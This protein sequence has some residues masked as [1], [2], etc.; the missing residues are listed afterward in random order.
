MGVR[1]AARFAVALSV[2]V[3]VSLLG[4]AGPT[5]P[6]E[7]RAATLPARLHGVGRLHRP[8]EPDRRA[9]RARRP[10][11]RGREER[12]DQG[13][14]Q[15]RRHDADG[16]RR[17]PHRG[18]QLLG[19]RPARPGARPELPGR[20]RTSTCS[21]RYDAPIGGT[22]PRWGIAGGDARTAARRRPAPTADGC[23]VSGR[24]SR[25]QA[26]GNVMT[27]AEQVLIEDWCQQFPSHSIGD[28][29]FGP[30]GA[31]YV[32]GGDGA[33]FNFVDYGQDGQPASTPA[34]TRR[35]ASAATLTPPTAEGGAL[36][37]PGPAH[38]AATRR[39]STAR[40]SASTRTPA[41]RC[42]TTRSPASADAERAPDR[43]LRPAQPVPVHDPA[44]HQRALGRRR[45]LERL[46]GDRPDR[47]TRPA[48]RRELR[49]ALLRG[50]RPPV[51]ATT[52][53]T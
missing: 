35:A 7:A 44:G 39:R 51:A 9:L 25:L 52:A 31:L 32:S 28:L 11:L 42:P 12:P 49:L 24:L 46:G 45:R 36:R 14:R 30:D 38:A 5:R 17:P 22:A 53:P 27:G 47:R 37:A 23:V 13:L 6:R 4:Q 2:V 1:A 34:A 41:R 21:T 10:R 20:R 43:R 33:S 18:P 29:A 26:T 50:R 15:P 8:D 48:R 3:V 40:S 19:P 16:L